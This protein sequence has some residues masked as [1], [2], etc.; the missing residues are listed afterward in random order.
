MTGNGRGNHP[1]V[2]ARP[3]APGGGA[4]HNRVSPV[5]GR[6]PVASAEPHP[7][8]HLHPQEESKP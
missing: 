1:P 7:H 8:P 4:G 5:A 2:A 3:L 6:G